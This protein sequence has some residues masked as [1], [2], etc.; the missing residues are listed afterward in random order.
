MA[1]G[2]HDQGPFVRVDTTA[3]E[4]KLAELLLQLEELD[5]V[6]VYQDRDGDLWLFVTDDPTER[7]SWHDGTSWVPDACTREHVELLYG[8]LTQR[9]G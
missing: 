2:G 8:P 7:G 4:A 1:T 3:A 6:D 9:E 5:Q